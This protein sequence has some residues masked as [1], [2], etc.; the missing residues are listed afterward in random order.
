MTRT[1]RTALVCL[2]LSC[3]VSVFMGFFLARNRHDVML[4]FKAVYY[5]T[6]CLFQNADPYKQGEPLRVYLADG[7]RILP[8]EGGL[9]QN[10]T[11][12]VYFPITAIFTAPF[13][14][15]PWG[16]AHLLWMILTAGSLVLAG[17]LMWNFSA[18]DSP[19]LSGFLICFLLA[20]SEILFA[21]GNP[22][23]IVVSLCAVT[24]WCFLKERFV[25]AGVLCLAASLA[26]KPHDAGPVWLYFLLAGAPYRKRALQTLLV[27]AVLGLLAILW[28]S[29]VAPNWMQELHSNLLAASATG[30]NNSPGL[31]NSVR[32][33]PSMIIDLQS[34]ISGFW[35]DPRIYDSVS[36][37]VCGAPLLVWSVRTL[38]ARISPERAWIALAAVVPLALVVIYHRPYDAK[39]LLL[40]VPACGL[41]WAEGKPVRWVALGLSTAGIVLTS[42]FPLL[43][44]MVLTKNMHISTAGLSR[45][46]LTDMLMRPTPLILLA[47]GIFYLWIYARRD[48]QRG[49][50]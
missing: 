47:M 23:G 20:N 4:D 11:W 26:I 48:P 1:Q 33:G 10:L 8:Y 46:T 2:L 14:M 31:G 18:K 16:P 13:A 19:V 27:T 34:V 40:T 36:Y 21:T 45:Q 32:Y 9:R 43:I 37:L 39:L 29:R 38:R 17:F 50:P 24:V 15:L 6:R 44:F 3:G 12:D 25:W 35:N 22:A 42:D 30:G 28:V 7:E 49:C 5:D 41:L